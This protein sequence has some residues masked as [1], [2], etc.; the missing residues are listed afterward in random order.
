MRTTHRDYS[1]SS[2]D[3]YR[4]CH[5]DV[6][7]HDPL[8][9]RQHSAWFP[10]RLA[11]WK[12]SLFENKRAFAD[13]CAK[14]AHLWF[15]GFGDL[16]GY[17]ISEGGDA[18]FAIVTTLGCRWL[19]EE[20]LQWVLANWGGRPPY[21][22]T[23]ITEFQT[24]EASVLQRYG[25]RRQATFDTRRF[26]LTGELPPR[27]P[28]EPGF[29]IVDMATHPDYRAQRILRDN[30][31]GARGDV[32]E[33][34]LRQELEFYNHSH[35]GPIYHASTD[36]CVMA[37]DGRFVAGCEALIDARN[38]EADIERVCTHS[39]F[40]HRGFARAVIQEC[41][42][43]LRDIGMRGAYIT[44]YSPEAIGLYNSLGAAS[45]ITN[46][47]YERPGERRDSPE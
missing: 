7:R 9:S 30:A 13:F 8:K 34:V 37:A 12:Y 2:N 33:E 18:G 1:E 5:L 19:Y 4:L 17:A 15:D 28:L 35:D 32:P 47:V 23:E 16:A 26:D 10:G 36:L 11:D 22:S 27:A 38:C 43:R 24:L 6:D 21:P 20:I 41:L 46:F 40:R 45:G 14:N 39:D 3:F 42:H 31:F 29:V 44:G 25:F